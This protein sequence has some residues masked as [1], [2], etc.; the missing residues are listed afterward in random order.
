MSKGGG[1][2]RAGLGGGDFFVWRGLERKDEENRGVD[3]GRRE[4]NL[5]E[6][7]E[8]DRGGERKQ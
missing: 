5:E 4:S 2:S 6:E 3:E 7:E 8:E 1:W